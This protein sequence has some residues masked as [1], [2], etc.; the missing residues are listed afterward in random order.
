MEEFKAAKVR[1]AMRLRDSDDQ[2]VQKANI[3]VK[4]ERKWK[5]SRALREAEEHLQ[6]A[7]IMGTVTQGRLG[8]GVITRASWKKAKA[9]DCRGMVQDEI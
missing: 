8:L 2:V 5:A 9:K 7:D 4:K 6:H 1:L 3:M